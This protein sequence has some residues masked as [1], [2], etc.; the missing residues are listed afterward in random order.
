VLA[1]PFPPTGAGNDSGASPYRILFWFV[2]LLGCLGFEVVRRQQQLAAAAARR[3]RLGPAAVA[4]DGGSSGSSEAAVCG[5]EAGCCFG[6]SAAAART[7]GQHVAQWWVWELC[8]H[9]ALCQTG[10][11][12]PSCVHS[13]Y[14]SGC[15][16]DPWPASVSSK[17]SNQG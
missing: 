3:R 7:G 13:H 9:S 15:S 16:T 12:L 1:P 10:L 4:A 6:F 5:V 8:L 2:L 14:H 17:R 11:A